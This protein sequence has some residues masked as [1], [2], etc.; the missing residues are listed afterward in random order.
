MLP[1]NDWYP[2]LAR[3]NVELVADGVAEVRERSIVTTAGR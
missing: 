1:S 2:T 3:E